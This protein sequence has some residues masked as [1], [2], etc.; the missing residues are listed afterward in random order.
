MDS[1]Q[2]CSAKAGDFRKRFLM[3]PVLRNPRNFSRSRKIASKAY[4]ISTL[5]R[6]ERH[7]YP[8]EP[9]LAVAGFGGNP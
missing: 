3:R 7:A 8:K 1:W 9:L 2:G 4:K 5:E 6:E